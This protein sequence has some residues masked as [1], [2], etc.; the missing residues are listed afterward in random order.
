MKQEFAIYWIDLIGAG[1]ANIREANAGT[2]KGVVNS[3]PNVPLGFAG[4]QIIPAQNV[5]KD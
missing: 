2:I 5:A 4:A 3:F 1:I